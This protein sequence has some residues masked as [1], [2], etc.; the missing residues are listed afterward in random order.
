MAALLCLGV[1]V[2]TIGWTGGVSILGLG[3]TTGVASLLMFLGLDPPSFS[4]GFGCCRC[5]GGGGGGIGSVRSKS[6]SA[7]WESVR[8]I[9]PDKCNS[10]NSKAAWMAITAATA[11][12]RSLLLM[13]V[14]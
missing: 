2:A 6:V 11:P 12:P 4:L 1:S 10:A 3:A 13:S 9:F 5:G 7:L 8:S 14:R